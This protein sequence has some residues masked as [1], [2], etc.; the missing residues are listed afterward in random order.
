MLE[1][2]LGTIRTKEGR[3]ATRPPSIY[4]Q[5]KVNTWNNNAENTNN[6]DTSIEEQRAEPSPAQANKAD[7]QG[8]EEQLLNS[9]KIHDINLRKAYIVLYLEEEE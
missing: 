9:M 6:E 2:E 8:V 7:E 4:Q 5:H 1:S 3:Y